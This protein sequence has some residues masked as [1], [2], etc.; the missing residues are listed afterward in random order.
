MKIG[1]LSSR[2]TLP[3]SDGNDEWPKLRAVMSESNPLYRLV[4]GIEDW[5]NQF[6][7]SWE[8]HG[9]LVSLLVT[10]GMHPRDSREI[11]EFRE[12]FAPWFFCARRWVSGKLGTPA[13]GA[14]RSRRT[15]ID[16]VLSD[17]S[18]W[19]VGGGTAVVITPGRRGATGAELDAAFQHAAAGDELPIQHDLLL[20]AHT[21]LF[22]DDL[23]RAV[24]DAAT[25]A[26]VVLAQWIRRCLEERGLN[27]DEALSV[28]NEANGIAELYRLSNALGLCVTPS[29]NQVI[30]RI[31]RPRNLA[32]H[33]GEG[34]SHETARKA[35][36]CAQIIV[37]EVAPLRLP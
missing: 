12:S 23:R 35:F 4:A 28:T 15:S 24:V 9:A 16:G 6:N 18:H 37:E 30:D 32:V 8:L 36:D 17:G 10:P 5:G 1:S 34:P 33:A 27:S 14:I 11:V 22:S 21:A 20:E 26:E 29:K 31:A 7:D 2:I 19:G 25:A 3:H 13:N